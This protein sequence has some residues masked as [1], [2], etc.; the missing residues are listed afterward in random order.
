MGGIFFPSIQS[1]LILLKQK[2]KTSKSTGILD[3]IFLVT[4]EA[5]LMELSDKQ[6]D[7]LG[8][9]PHPDDRTSSIFCIFSQHFIADLSIC[10]L[11][12]YSL[13]SF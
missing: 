2:I 5:I 9:T 6:Y 11:Y 12:L 8:A 13:W 4:F 7:E 1:N 10:A 3:S